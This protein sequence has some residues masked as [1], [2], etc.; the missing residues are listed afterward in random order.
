MT[1]P[2]PIV[3][4]L[5]TAN[6][7]SESWRLPPKP[8]TSITLEP[9]PTHPH[10]NELDLVDNSI[11]GT[12]RETLD[13]VES[14]KAIIAEAVRPR[15]WLSGWRTAGDDFPLPEYAKWAMFV[16]PDSVSATSTVLIG[17]VLHTLPVGPNTVTIPTLKA[18]QISWPGGAS[19][20]QFAC[21]SDPDDVMMLREV[22]V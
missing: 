21:G 4:D 5:V 16:I 10:A 1:L 9:P 2:T 17:S 7:E 18:S 13:A 20:I 8:S 3:D 6:I 12:A 22:N 11:P 14:L 19:K 15:R